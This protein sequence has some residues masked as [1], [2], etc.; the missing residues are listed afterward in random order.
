MLRLC[1]AGSEDIQYQFSSLK[2][3]TA[4]SA[5]QVTLQAAR[6]RTPVTVTATAV[7][8]KG[9]CPCVKTFVSAKYEA[10][11]THRPPLKESAGSC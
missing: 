4:M 9:N 2:D 1:S 5:I 6:Y 11:K 10:S 8:G 3:Q 7:T